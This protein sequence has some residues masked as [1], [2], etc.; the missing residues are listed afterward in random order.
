MNN[1]YRLLLFLGFALFTI[2]AN[3]Q[4]SFERRYPTTRGEV[5][6]SSLSAAGTGYVMLG[7]EVNEND[8]RD[9]VNVTFLSTKGNIQRSFSIDYDSIRINQVGNAVN[10]GDGFWAISAVLE[11]DS[12]NKVITQFDLSTN[13]IWTTI[14]GQLTDNKE[15]EAGRSGLAAV[16]GKRLFHVHNVA[17]VNG[18]ID[19]Q[20]TGLDSTGA[21][22]FIRNIGLG[23]EI[24]ERLM[25]M[26]VGLDSSIMLLGTTDNAEAPLFLT[27]LDTA[28]REVWTKTYNGD[29]GR[30][31][32]DNGFEIT[33]L[34]DSTWVIVGSINASRIRT[35][36]GFVL[37]LDNDGNIIQGRTFSTSG[38]QDNLYPNGIIGTLDTSVVVSMIR[39][40]ASGTIA[41]PLVIKYD[42]DSVITYQTLLDTCIGINPDIA[43]LVTVDSISASFLTTTIK[44]DMQIPY[45]AKL[46]ALGNTQCQESAEIIIIDSVGFT[47]GS[48]DY[49]FEDIMVEDSIEVEKETYSNYNPP[50][51]QL[52]DTIYCPQDPINYTVDGTVRGGVSYIWEDN[53]IDP[54]RTLTEEGMY[55]LTVTV[56]E[57]LCFTLCD[58]MTISQRN[59][60]QVSIAKDFSNFCTS[61]AG[62]LEAE[63]MGA[64]I[65]RFTWNTG[66]DQAV[67][68]VDGVPASY[69]VEVEDACGNTANASASVTE[70]DLIPPVVA[71]IM[72][73]CNTLTV[74]GTGFI[75]QTWSTGATTASIRVNSPGTYSVV[76]E[77]ECGDD[78]QTPI[79]IVLSEGDLPPP[80]NAEILLEC[81]SPRI[82]SLVGSGFASQEWSTG[83][84]TEAIEITAAGTY[85]VTVTGESVSTPTGDCQNTQIRNINVSE[86]QIQKSTGCLIWPNAL[87][88]L[89]PEIENQ[90]FGPNI[91]DGCRNLVS[92]EMR[93][94]NRW[95]KNIFTSND[96]SL[97]WN[98]SVSGNNQPGGVYFYWARYD[99]GNTVCEREGDITL[100]R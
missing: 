37:Q 72:R 21:I 81:G 40:A 54:V 25:K 48:I 22:I 45:L 30:T 32:S 4:E 71:E 59:F 70:A 82:L 35:N 52:P 33:Q 74:V 16:P 68:S 24:N 77:D 23:D 92:F 73:D 69:N 64:A 63:T 65:T 51:L 10:Q 60:P 42:L 88:P 85:S 93:I 96:S 27:K 20:L 76:V 31:F 13:L 38:I 80:V 12:L 53:S 44:D 34:L 78:V 86:E 29:F 8:E 28:G 36:G 100:I 3:A 90:T 15:L 99:D 5:V 91:L 87:M 7:V 50:I 66:S 89:N 1:I 18:T 57:D 55:M 2:L 83:E 95:G 17:G 62:Q 75:G 56:R 47:T 61:G 67:I 84:T 26:H 97:R 14:V 94:Y 43:S 79:E 98:G 46:D 11:K 19:L 49:S 41:I 58:T 6:A 9:M 39:Q